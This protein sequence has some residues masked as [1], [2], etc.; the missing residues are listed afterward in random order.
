MIMGL[1]KNGFSFSNQGDHEKSYSANTQ[2][3]SIAA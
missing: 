3:R 1:S 2:Y